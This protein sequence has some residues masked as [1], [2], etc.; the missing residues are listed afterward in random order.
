[1]SRGRDDRLASLIYAGLCVFLVF[2][3]Y[4]AGVTG[5]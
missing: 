1:L 5:A 2:I 3:A 4:R